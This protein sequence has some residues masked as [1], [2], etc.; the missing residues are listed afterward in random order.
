MITKRSK[1]ENDSSIL[2]VVARS[3]S[4]SSSSG[5]GKKTAIS[6]KKRQCK[7]TDYSCYTLPL[8][9]V[10]C[11]IILYLLV[12]FYS[13]MSSVSVDGGM[14][15]AP[16]FLEEVTLTNSTSPGRVADAAGRVGEDVKVEGEQNAL[17]V[18]KRLY[19]GQ[20]GESPKILNQL[21]AV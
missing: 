18:G 5:G 21:L 19:G 6:G 2:P 13:N 17:V 15:G 12:L 7:P 8:V 3:P 14:V 20:K 4:G 1:N 9:T 11:I 16:A 10:C